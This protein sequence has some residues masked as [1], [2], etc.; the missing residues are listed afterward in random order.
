M[1]NDDVKENLAFENEGRNDRKG[2]RAEEKPEKKEAVDEADG[3]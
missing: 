3:N 2:D 1:K